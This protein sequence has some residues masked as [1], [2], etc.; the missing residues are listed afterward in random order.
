MI[1]RCTLNW[2]ASNESV[3][4]SCSYPNKNITFKIDESSSFPA[5]L[6]FEIQYQQGE[7]DITAVQLCE[8]LSN[9]LLHQS[10]RNL[11]TWL[12]CS[13][14]LS[15]LYMYADCESNMQA[16]E[17]EPWSSMDYS[18]SSERASVHK[19]ASEW[20]WWCQWELGGACQ[21]HTTRLEGWKHLRFG[22]TIELI[23]NYIARWN[24]YRIL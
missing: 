15:L 6:A 12:M 18:F 1:H 20:R 21:Q 14:K 2:H 13:F 19:D 23:A 17:S 4:V 16:T 11:P 5:Y 7:Q 9:S 8:V 24:L 10:L 3:R 22:N